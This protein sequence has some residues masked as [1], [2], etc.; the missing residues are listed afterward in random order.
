ME[1]G[2]A[3]MH[4]YLFICTVSGSIVPGSAASMKNLAVKA[5]SQTLHLLWVQILKQPSICR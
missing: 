4:M 2:T 1:I 5:V 3:N